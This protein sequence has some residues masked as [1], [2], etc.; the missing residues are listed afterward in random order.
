[1]REYITK[2]QAWHIIGYAAITG[3]LEKARKLL[4]AAPNADVKKNTIAYWDESGAWMDPIDC[5]CDTGTYA[6]RTWV[7]SNCG[8]HETIRCSGADYNGMPLWS[9]CTE[10][11]AEMRSKG[12][13][14]DFNPTSKGDISLENGKVVALKKYTCNVCG[15]E[16]ETT[17]G[18]P[19][20]RCYECG[21]YNPE[22]YHR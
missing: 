11:G 18:H 17:A 1:M 19:P 13:W 9:Y 4:D 7:C 12:Y 6:D 2:A 22:V 15:A 16:I 21:A 3:N 14:I 20:E 5:M 10:C 8:N